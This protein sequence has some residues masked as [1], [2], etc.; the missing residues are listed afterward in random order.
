MFI[1]KK[2]NIKFFQ[3][4]LLKYNKKIASSFFMNNLKNDIKS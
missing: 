3:N 4:I 1:I 2:Y